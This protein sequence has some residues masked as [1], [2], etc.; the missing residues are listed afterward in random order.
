MAVVAPTRRRLS[1]ETR[2]LLVTMVLSLA[3]L[4][5]LARIRFSVPVA[6]NPIAPVLTQLAP[7]PVFDQLTAAI[8]QVQ[9]R[10]APLLVG[11]DVRSFGADRDRSRTVT[12][13]RIDNESVVAMLNGSVIRDDVDVGS[14]G[15]VVAHDPAS[16]LTLLSAPANPAP[17]SY[18][19]PTAAW[20]PRQPQAPRYLMAG[21]IRLGEV[22]TRPIFIGPIEAMTSRIWSDVVWGLSDSTGLRPGTFLFTTEGVLAGL[23]SDIDGRLVIVPA[24]TLALSVARLRSE[25]HREYGWLGIEAQPLTPA[26]SSS[27]HAPLGVIVTWVDA[28]GPA[29]GLL[30]PGDVIIAIGDEPL[31][32]HEHWRAVAARV[33]IGQKVAIRV[34]RGG[35][36][37]D[38]ELESAPRAHNRRPDALGLTM[39][40][41]ESGSEIV[42]VAPGS[43]AADAGLLP[44][45]VITLIADRTAPTPAIVQ[46]VFAAAPPDRPTLV[47]V[48]RNAA[49]HVMALE[50]R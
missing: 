41:I 31:S 20:S 5:V 30:D 17:D 32:T 1:R 18:V 44:G 23:V 38:V 24:E 13:L 21:E 6:P 15:D 3:T 27:T 11:I 37:R 48:T 7:P 29:A 2:L 36:V 50:K 39:R 8:V 40:R 35:Q 14:T 12:A 34:Q 4:W 9:G 43:V 28:D 46:R 49:H 26:V 33:G 42:E 22:A 25:G 47:A 10:I 19:P 16:G 45:D